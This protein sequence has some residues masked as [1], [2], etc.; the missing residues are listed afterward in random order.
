MRRVKTQQS[1]GQIGQST[2]SNEDVK[3][4]MTMKYSTVRYSIPNIVVPKTAAARD[5][6]NAWWAAVERN[7]IKDPNIVCLT[8]DP[9]EDDFKD[10]DGNDLITLEEGAEVFLI[11]RN[12]TSP[13][14]MIVDVTWDGFDSKGLPLRLSISPSV[15]WEAP[16]SRLLALWIEH[17][18]NHREHAE[19]ASHLFTAENEYYLKDHT[20][21]ETAP[22][23]TPGQQVIFKMKPWSKENA[24]DRQ[25]K[26]PRPP[27]R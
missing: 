18:K 15:H 27:I 13:D 14:V 4:K 5:V 17:Y 19:V 7:Q 10:E 20:G 12:K 1:Q 6:V 8:K 11:P 16:R 24:A 21:V 25:R 3:L 2:L 9:E 22:P 23:W 26:R